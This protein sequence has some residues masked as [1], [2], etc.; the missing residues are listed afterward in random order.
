MLL[1]IKRILNK[2]YYKQYIIRSVVEIKKY[3]SLMNGKH[4]RRKREN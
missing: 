1:E 3:K 2:I 4:V